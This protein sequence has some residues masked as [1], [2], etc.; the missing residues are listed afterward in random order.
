MVISRVFPCKFLQIHITSGSG[1][2]RFIQNLLNCCRHKYDMSI[3]RIFLDLIFGGILLLGLN[4]APP[5]RLPVLQPFLGQEEGKTK[6]DQ[7]Y[8]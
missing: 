3:S 7:T 5:A 4:C 2:L 6:Q 8:T 1:C